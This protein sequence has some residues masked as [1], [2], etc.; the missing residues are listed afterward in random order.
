MYKRRARLIFVS[1]TPDLA[2]RAVRI[3][4]ALGGSWIEAR[5]CPMGTA[6]TDCDLLVTLDA[7]ALAA[8]QCAVPGYRHAHWPLSPSSKDGDIAS[9]VEG[10]IGGMR[11]LARLDASGAPGA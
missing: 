6:P 10:L 8:H 7:T 4:A 2:A 5:A 11:L 9:H 1:S 3:A